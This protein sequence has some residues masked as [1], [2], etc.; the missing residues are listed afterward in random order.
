M[1]DSTVEGLIDH[2]DSLGSAGRYGN[3]DVQFMHAGDGCVHGEMFP[4]KPHRWAG[5]RVVHH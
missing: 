4:S 5:G 1:L 3:G 2:T